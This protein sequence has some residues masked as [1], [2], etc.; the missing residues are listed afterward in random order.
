[1]AIKTIQRT[2]F[3]ETELITMIQMFP[4]QNSNPQKMLKMS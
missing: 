4:N 3:K 1:M 2:K